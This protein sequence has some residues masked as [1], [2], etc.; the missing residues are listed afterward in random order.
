[1]CAIVSK[2]KLSKMQ[3]RLVKQEIILS[4]SKG[5]FTQLH[6]LTFT[7]LLHVIKIITIEMTKN[8]SFRLCYSNTNKIIMFY[9]FTNK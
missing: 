9:C 8:I 3:R 2:I 5:W 4:A 1:M 7:Q 6:D